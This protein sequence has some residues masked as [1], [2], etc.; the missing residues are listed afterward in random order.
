MFIQENKV[1]DLNWNSPESV[2]PVL[3]ARSNRLPESLRVLCGFL[4]RA[5]SH[6]PRTADSESIRASLPLKSY[7]F[8]PLVK[9]AFLNHFLEATRVVARAAAQEQGSTTTTSEASASTTSSND[10]KDN[11]GSS[12]PLLFFV[13]LGF[14]VVFTNLW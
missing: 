7:P 10:G 8:R 6:G 1:D 11:N 14:G 9:M 2:V 5:T 12:S 3:P 4:P 13:A